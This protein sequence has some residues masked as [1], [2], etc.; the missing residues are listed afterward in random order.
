[1]GEA[2]RR[3][4]FDERVAQSKRREAARHEIKERQWA[5]HRQKMMEK[6][7]LGGR[8]TG[9]GLLRAAALAVCGR[10]DVSSSL[11]DR[12]TFSRRRPI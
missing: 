1:M 4:T 2:K 5:E 10:N 12:V 9:R 8:Q 6:A 3:G 7:V 11:T